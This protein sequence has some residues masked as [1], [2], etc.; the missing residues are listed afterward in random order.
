MRKTALILNADSAFGDA[1]A[2]ALWNAGWSI[3]IFDGP[4]ETL[5]DAARDMD[6]IVT[7]DAAHDAHQHRPIQRAAQTGA[8]T[9]IL[10][11]NTGSA[12]AVQSQM[13]IAQGYRAQGIAAVCLSMEDLEDVL[14]AHVFD[15]A[16]TAHAGAAIPGKLLLQGCQH[17][18]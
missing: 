17:A 5:Q 11:L 7:S 16:V 4:S 15:N 6:V 9:V 2:E 13:Q 8:P 14:I 3:R 18:P 12:Q 10:P 1:A